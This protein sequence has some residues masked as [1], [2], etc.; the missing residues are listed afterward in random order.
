MKTSIEWKDVAV[1]CR[2]G[3]LGT[4]AALERSGKV[5]GD[6]VVMFAGVMG[7]SELA[8]LLQG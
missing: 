7:R 8:A 2:D 5:H 1:S 6:A 3:Q 4:A